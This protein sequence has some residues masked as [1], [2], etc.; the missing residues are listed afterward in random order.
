MSELAVD[1]FRV[2]VRYPSPVSIHTTIVPVILLATATLP[3]REQLLNF[4]L[5]RLD[6]NPATLQDVDVSTTQGPRV[7]YHRILNLPHYLA[8]RWLLR[9]L[10]VPSPSGVGAVAQLHLDN[11]GES[12]ADAGC[13][14]RA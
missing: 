7:R 6:R 14:G 1:L 13:G 9:V 12:R 8:E 5:T 11:C 4:L 3:V 2:R 10:L